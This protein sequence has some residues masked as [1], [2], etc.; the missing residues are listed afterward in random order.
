MILRCFR[1]WMTS[2]ASGRIGVAGGDESDDAAVQR[3]RTARSRP[4]RRAPPVPPRPRRRARSPCS[5]RSRRLPTSTACSWP[6]SS[7][8]RAET[9]APGWAVTSEAAS[10]V[11][12]ALGG[13]LRRRRRPAGAGSPAS[14]VAARRSS[15]A[16]LIAPGTRQGHD[17]GQLGPAPCQGAGLVEGERVALGQPLERRASLDQ[18]AVPRQPGHARQDRRRRGQHQRRTGRPPPARRP[19]G[20]R[21]RA[22]RA[23]SRRPGSSPA[24]ISTTGKK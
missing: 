15:S 1:S 14:A 19:S 6:S 18:H 2:C 3:P 12:P 7:R 17:P 9:P 22:S 16:S 5:A 10:G 13:R 23:S 8:H 21:H 4:G 11:E 20:A 24:T